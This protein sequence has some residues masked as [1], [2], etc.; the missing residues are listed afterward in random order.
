MVASLTSA[1][2]PALTTVARSVTSGAAKAVGKSAGQHMAEQVAHN[3]AKNVSYAATESLGASGLL[4]AVLSSAVNKSAGAT[5]RMHDVRNEPDYVQQYVRKRELLNIGLSILTN[6]AVQMA[7]HKPVSKM[8]PRVPEGY[9]RMLLTAPGLY[10]CEYLSRLFA[11]KE[12]L[13]ARIANDRPTFQSVIHHRTNISFS[14]F[15]PAASNRKA[16]AASQN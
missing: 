3:V 9:V 14:A 11:G 7:L 13:E 2:A 15:N 4:V 10:L 1:I 12:K 6:A 8:M 5:N 16:A